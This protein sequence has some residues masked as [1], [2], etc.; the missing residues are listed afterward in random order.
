VSADVPKAK[1]N[2]D[3]HWDI[4]LNTYESMHKDIKLLTVA[5]VDLKN[6]MHH[7]PCD[8]MRDHIKNHGT[9]VNEVRKELL[10]H[11]KMHE[12]KEQAESLER[13]GNK[14]YVRNIKTIVIGGLVLSFIVGI[15]GAVIYAFTHGFQG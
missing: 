10:G 13:L 7:P 9:D 12:D 3:N 8:V 11:K 2:Q 14:K 1:P 15:S 6:D 4:V 5:I